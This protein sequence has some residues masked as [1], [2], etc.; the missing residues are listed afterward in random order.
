MKSVIAS[1]KLKWFPP[2]CRKVIG[3]A[4]LHALLIGLQKIWATYS[5]VKQNQ[6][7]TPFA[8]IDR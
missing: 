4:M 8:Q 7:V 1:E 6:F 2:E 5:E 3:F